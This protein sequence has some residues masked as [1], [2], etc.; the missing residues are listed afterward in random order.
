MH[1]CRGKIMMEVPH[2]LGN[3]VCENK[4]GACPWITIC[5]KRSEHVEERPLLSELEHDAELV[6]SLV[7]HSAKHAHEVGMRER[8]H[9]L[10]LIKKHNLVDFKKGLD[11]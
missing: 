2:A 5:P 1:H 3:A 10:C 11:V 6:R 9:Y 7:P 8:A 4:T